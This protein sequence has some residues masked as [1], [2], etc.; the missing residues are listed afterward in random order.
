[1]GTDRLPFRCHFIHR[2][3]GYSA[4]KRYR[5][6]AVLYTTLPVSLQTF[7]TYNISLFHCVRQSMLVQCFIRLTHWH[8]VSTC[9]HLFAADRQDVHERPV[10]LCYLPVNRVYSTVFVI[11]AVQH[12]VMLIS[13]WATLKSVRQ[14]QALPNSMPSEDDLSSGKLCCC[15]YLHFYCSTK[16]FCQL[17]IILFQQY[18]FNC[19]GCLMR[20]LRTHQSSTYQ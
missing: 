20:T 14:L 8:L 5:F 7:Y 1:M 4:P 13:H 17:L 16:F 6:T 10:F 12:S 15:H 19:V 11:Y 9:L 18:I 3:D 2:C